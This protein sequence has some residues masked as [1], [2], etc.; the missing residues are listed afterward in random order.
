LLTKPH[1]QEGLSRAYVQAVAAACGMSYSIPNPDYGIDLT[2]D[3]ILIRGARRSPSGWRLDIQAKSTALA[4]VDEPNL[5]YD[6][7]VSAYENLR[8][9]DV[10]CPRILV[11]LVL[12]AEEADWLAQT[13]EHLLLRH[14]AYWLSLR[15][16]E[17]T[18]RQQMVRVT[19]PRANVFSV[20][21]L[22]AIMDRVK[23]GMAP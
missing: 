16:W 11:V 22:H 21:A 3:D 20:A 7:E 13:E 8:A 17:P 1:R 12:P 18:T 9:S 23:K 15:G 19:I 10:P 4:F 2:L 6:L 14:C 5:R